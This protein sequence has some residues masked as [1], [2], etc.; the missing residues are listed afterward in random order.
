MTDVACPRCSC[1][2]WVRDVLVAAPN[3]TGELHLRR[4]LDPLRWTCAMCG[5]QASPRGLLNW[6]LG[7]TVAYARPLTAA[8]R[9]R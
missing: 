8:A 7:G 6:R 5:Y 2:I 4:S 1:G 9:S 3:P